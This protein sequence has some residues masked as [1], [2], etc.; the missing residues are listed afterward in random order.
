[1]AY[2]VNQVLFK[3]DQALGCPEAMEELDAVRACCVVQTGGK[4]R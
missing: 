4:Q 3:L 2:W 1:M